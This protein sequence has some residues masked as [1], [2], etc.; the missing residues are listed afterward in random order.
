MIQSLFILDSSGAIIIEKHFR[1]IVPRQVADQFWDEAQ[2]VSPFFAELVPV[3]ATAKYYLVHVIRGGLFFLGVV[4][5][6]TTPLGVVEF[7]DRVSR[8]FYHY[9]GEQLNE[10]ALK[11]NFITAY[12]LLEEVNDAGYAFNTEP[13]IL[14][15]IVSI[16]SLLNQ[17]TDL[18][19][20]TGS[21]GISNIFPSGGL[22]TIPWRKNGVTKTTNEIYID[23][24]EEIDAIVESNG[25]LTYSKISGVIE[26]DSQLAGMPDIVL[27]LTGVGCIDDIGF[28]PCVRLKRWDQERVVSFI[29]PDGK[30]FMAK[31]I[32]RNNVPMPI[33]VKPQILIGEQNGTVHVMVGSKHVAP[34]NKEIE[35]IIVTIPFSKNCIGTSLTSKVGTVTFDE[36]TKVCR[37][38]IPQL[39][40]TVTPILEGSFTFDPEHPPSKPTIGVYFEIQTWSCS[41]IK[42]DTLSILNEKYSHFKG[43]K[44]LTCGGQVQIRS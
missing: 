16:P 36:Q 3:I 13:N 24:T 5:K 12:H 20:G 26:V 6:D 40:K 32:V 23:I 10:R 28:H 22:T 8:I 18:V 31:Y 7:L 19:M 9:F 39:P 2:K 1:G 35:N 37:W 30:F 15:G 44:A 41:G 21:N 43:V 29:P 34:G 4:A 11:D 33:Y 38:K 17:T 25:S 42:V 14:E 27:K